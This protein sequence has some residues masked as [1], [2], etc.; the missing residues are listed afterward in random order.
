MSTCQ[1][2]KQTLLDSFKGE[3]P[4]LY[5]RYLLH[6]D[7]WIPS[8]M[9][10]TMHVFFVV[11]AFGPCNSDFVV[12]SPSQESDFVHL[13][14]EASAGESTGKS[15]ESVA[16]RACRAYL[17]ILFFHPFDDGQSRLA[18]L[19]FD[20]VLTRAGYTVS[21]P[22]RIFL[23][24]K[25]AKDSEGAV[26]LVELVNQLIVKPKEDWCSPLQKWVADH[27]PPG[28]QYKSRWFDCQSYPN[29]VPP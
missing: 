15:L 19:V 6:L 7:R 10:G 27:P 29:D 13:L 16:L 9:F 2:M 26:K 18:R 8:N 5:L 4:L 14:S 17:D 1:S 28:L 22:E 24:S 21:Q 20:F 23:F 3:E 12:P 25:S 11:L